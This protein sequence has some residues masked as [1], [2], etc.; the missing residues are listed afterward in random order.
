MSAEIFAAIIPV[1]RRSEKTYGNSLMN[2]TPNT[3][4]YLQDFFENTAQSRPTLTALDD[5]EKILSYEELNERSNHLAFRL[6]DIGCGPNDRVCILSSKN[7]HAYIGVLGTL[8]SGSCWV[9][10]SES[11][12]PERIANLLKSIQP[13]AIVT[14]TRFENEITQLVTS[15]GLNIEIINAETDEGR[16]LNSPRVSNRTPEDLAYIIFTSGST[17]TPKGVM[18]YHRNISH[19]LNNC[20]DFFNVEEGKRFAHHSELTFDPSI[21]DLFYCWGTGGTL[22]PMNKRS[23]RINPLAYIAKNKINFLFTVPSVIA[24][25]D[26]AGVISS[27]ALN[28]LE[29]LVLTGEPLPADMVNTW[30]EHHPNCHVYN[31]YGTTETAIISHWIRFDDSL[32]K[33]TIAPVG[34]P[35]PGVRVQLMDGNKAVADGDTGENVVWGSQIAPGYWGNAAEN[36]T[37]FI[38][39]YEDNLLPQQAYRT[40]DLLQKQPDGNYTFIGRADRQVKVRGHRVELLEVENAIMACDGVEEVAAILSPSVKEFQGEHIAAMICAA[41]E[42]STA[43]LTTKLEQRLPAYMIPSRLI[44]SNNHLPRNN[45]GKINFEEVKAAFAESV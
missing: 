44:V 12:P 19:F 29:H 21:L 43:E 3:Y 17:G 10:F 13:K 41:G 32:P 37:R 40:G 7:R 9:P 36:T 4:I 11:Y 39:G 33:G 27:E 30:K 1:I 31:F 26:K 28:S 5:G 38:T 34:A 15:E 8:K 24:S 42:L 23:Y 2:I 14:E 22:V 18:V 6:Q 16:A 45:N 20:F 35:V 25:L